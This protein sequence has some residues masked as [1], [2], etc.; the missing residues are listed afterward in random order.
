[1]EQFDF[2]AE[3]VLTAFIIGAIFGAIV[4]LHLRSGK[5][6]KLSRVDNLMPKAIPVRSRESHT[7]RR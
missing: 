5:K 2:V 6:I 3:A 1:M 7:R 4:A